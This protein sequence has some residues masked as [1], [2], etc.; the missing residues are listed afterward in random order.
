M[1]QLNSK[2]P[3]VYCFITYRRRFRSLKRDSQKDSTSQKIL[4]M[5]KALLTFVLILLVAGDFI[6]EIDGLLRAGRSRIEKVQRD[7]VPP[8]EREA[9]D[10]HRV[11]IYFRRDRIENPEK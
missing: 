8:Y 10:L 2:G 4:T 5:G 7:Q 9:A 1:N 3:L 6:D 11:P